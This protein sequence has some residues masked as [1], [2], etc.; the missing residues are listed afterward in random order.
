MSHLDESYLNENIDGMY[1]EFLHRNMAK[2]EY[3]KNNN[4]QS[5][6]NFT[7]KMPRFVPSYE[8]KNNNIAEMRD[9][10]LY[11]NEYIQSKGKSSIANENND[12][13]KDQTEKKDP[14]CIYL[15]INVY[16]LLLFIVF[17]LLLVQLMMNVYM[18]KKINN[19]VV[20]QK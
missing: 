1:G 5:D 19:Y 15:K 4:L 18:I 11:N 14:D 8:R 3:I 20:L 7:S 16:S 12:S 9:I 6:E 2:Y 10:A 13:I 17:V